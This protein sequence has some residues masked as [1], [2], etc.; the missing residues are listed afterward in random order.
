MCDLCLQMVPMLS[1]SQGAA[2]ISLGPLCAV[3]TCAQSSSEVTGDRWVWGQSGTFSLQGPI[4]DVGML[5]QPTCRK[6]AC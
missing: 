2:E 3:A 5:Q 1:V 6:L 4:D